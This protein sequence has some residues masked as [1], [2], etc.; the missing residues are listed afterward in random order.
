MRRISCAQ[1][2][3]MGILSE[4]EQHISYDEIA[5]R[6]G[7]DPRT[8]IRAVKRLRYQGRL[9]V[10]ERGRGATPNRYVID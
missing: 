7:Y 10:A 4:G 3:V 6:T 2:A 8:I 1:L 5:V 9:H